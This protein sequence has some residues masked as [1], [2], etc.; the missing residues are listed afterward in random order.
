MCWFL[1]MSNLVFA[2]FKKPRLLV[3]V[4]LFVGIGLE[5]FAATPDA[6]SII[7]QI[8]QERRDWRTPKNLEESSPVTREIDAPTDSVV[9]SI[10]AIEFRGNVNIQSKE[11]QEFFNPYL[12][13]SYDYDGLQTL[14]RMVGEFYRS[15]GLWARGI[16]PEQTLESEKLIIEI[17]E[18]ELGSLIIEKMDED[19]RL[20]EDRARKIL[21]HGQKT[22]SAFDIRAF[23]RAV[24]N[25]DSLPG[26]T[27]AAVLKNG[28]EEGSTDALVRIANTPLL[29]GS[30]R[31]DNHGSRSTSWHGARALVLLNVDGVAEVGDQINLI[32]MQA[33][34]LEYYSV[35]GSLPITDSDVRVGISYGWMQYELGAPLTSLEAS[36]D[37]QTSNLFVSGTLFHLADTDVSG[38]FDL[39]HKNFFNETGA[40]VVS[41]KKTIDS[42]SMTASIAWRDSLVG[43]G[44]NSVMLMLTSG[45]LDLGDDATNLATDATTAQTQGG[46]SKIVI[47]FSRLTAIAENLILTGSLLAQV[48]NKN[49]DSGEKMSLGG[50]SGV[51]AYPGGEA[52]GDHG[53][54]AS[55]EIKR[56]L[57]DAMMVSAFY[58][59]GWI[60]QYHDAYPDF[61]SSNTAVH[62]NYEL[63]GFGVG[64]NYTTENK[65]E[66]NVLLANR[67]HNNPARDSAGNDADG[68]R[69]TPILWASLVKQF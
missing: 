13:R 34:G 6:G 10:S 21:L 37:S 27:A 4:F 53:A 69:R 3:G 42:V 55:I 30:A 47:T 22:E 16:L 38:R 51:R 67:L 31:V 48:S 1:R 7:Q 43:S 50:P 18:G 66:L 65:F 40:D 23:Q 68:S 14:A 54:L 33:R 58:D 11:L 57:S 41:S 24:K 59:H 49:L 64:L 62:N 56:Y 19:I 2:P 52:S 36:G 46:F 15:K 8:E 9:V 39:N 28:I 25:L 29:G 17:V 26:I 5:A 20:S 63:N 44:L 61:N 12:G 35:G 32:S 60:Q 45:D